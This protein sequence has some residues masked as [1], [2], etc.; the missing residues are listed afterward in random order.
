MSAT[1]ALQV[2]MI[3]IGVALVA[4]AVSAGGGALALGVVVGLL[5]IAAGGLRLWAERGR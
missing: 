5:F 1:A 3:V 2:L 4:R